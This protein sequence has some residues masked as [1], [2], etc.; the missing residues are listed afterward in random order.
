MVSIIALHAAIGVKLTHQIDTIPSLRLNCFAQPEKK[1]F[2]I[3]ATQVTQFACCVKRGLFAQI[4]CSEFV[5]R[6]ASTSR[7]LFNN[8]HNPSKDQTQIRNGLAQKS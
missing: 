1:V 4:R 5:G 3:F 7:P 8:A 2:T 6:P